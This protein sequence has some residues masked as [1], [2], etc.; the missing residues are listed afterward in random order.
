D[1]VGG[2][3]G[4]RERE[5][6]VTGGEAVQ[7]VDRAG[8]RGHLDLQ[9]GRGL[10]QSLGERAGVGVVDA[11]GAAGRD[12]GV[13]ARLALAVAGEYRASGEYGGQQQAYAETRRAWVQP[14]RTH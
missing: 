10:L 11:L 6:G 14:Q 2:D 9:P 12:D 5:R 3:V 4:G 7:I 1:R 13:P 8:G